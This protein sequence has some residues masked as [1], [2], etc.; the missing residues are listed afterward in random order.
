[1][2]ESRKN[3]GDVH[4][5]VSSAIEERKDLLSKDCEHDRNSKPRQNEAQLHLSDTTEL[6]IE[7]YVID[8]VT[9]KI[10]ERYIEY[11]PVVYFKRDGYFNNESFHVQ[12]NMIIFGKKVY[13]KILFDVKE[14]SKTNIPIEEYIFQKLICFIDEEIK[15]YI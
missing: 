8:T 7:D 6:G 4:K 10:R 11:D 13:F 3:M 5:D 2:Y 1:M 12:I 9:K 14:M 15:K